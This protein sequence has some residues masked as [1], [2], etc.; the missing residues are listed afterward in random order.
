MQDVRVTSGAAGADSRP[1][2]VTRPRGRPEL[3]VPLVG[4]AAA[5]VGA[6]VAPHTTFLVAAAV[7]SA[8]VLGSRVEWAALAVVCGSVFE[9]YLTRLSPWATEW[10][11]AVLLVAW[12]VRRAQGPLHAHRLAA[13]VRPTVVFGGV[14]VAAFLAHPHGRAGL[15]TCAKYAELALVMLVLADVLCG[16]LAPR[17]AARGY[18]LVCLVASAC[19]ILTA[20][21]D[22]R[23]RVVG[24]V[25]NSDTLAFF[26]IAAVP[27]VGT[28][29]SRADQPA[30]WVWASFA[31][32]VVAGVGTQSRPAVVAMV[33]MAVVAVL[34]GLLALRYAG[35]LVAVVTTGV[36][37]LIA[38]LPQPLGQALT[39]PQ[40]YSDTNISQRNDF[41]L[42]ALDMT[43]ASPLLGQGP[44][45][46]PLFHQDF[47]EV[48]ARD[49]DLG[50]AYSTALEASAEL[51]LLGLLA[52]HA[53]W[54]VPAAGARRRWR[55]D[56]SALTAGAL[57]AFVGLLV[58]SLLESEQRLLPLWFLAA[59]MLALG[60]P[61]PIRVP[62]LGA[63]L[64]GS[65]GHLVPES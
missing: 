65:S 58:A 30:W 43:R 4:A 60:R 37:L 24:P 42:A 13:A 1:P 3:L 40:R 63:A 21:V 2:P 51:G 64:G 5:G 16:P 32:L 62:V 53:V 61:A 35:A 36:A 55:R 49:R 31:T 52:L 15:G 26:L 23:H 20:V 34:T 7:V 12:V 6:G 59:L 50:T 41:R 28:V 25:A 38:V 19:G 8:V 48:D 46:Y 54:L 27:L 17:R 10:L 47:H 11:A 14:L 44:A 22:D 45:A 33:A 9:A 39:D 56:R 18:V 29:R 57:L